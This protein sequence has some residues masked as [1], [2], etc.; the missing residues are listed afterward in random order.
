MIKQVQAAV[1]G[2]TIEEVQKALQR[3]DWNPVKAEQQLK[4]KKKGILI[5]DFK[6]YFKF[7]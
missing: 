7:I 3:N 6:I 2:V 1:H 4:V 5:L